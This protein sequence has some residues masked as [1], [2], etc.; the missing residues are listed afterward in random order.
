MRRLMCFY[1]CT[2]YGCF[3]FRRCVDWSGCTGHIFHK[4]VFHLESNVLTWVYAD[5]ICH[6]PAFYFESDAKGNNYRTG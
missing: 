6:K 5:P 1:I 2:S 3:I 4:A